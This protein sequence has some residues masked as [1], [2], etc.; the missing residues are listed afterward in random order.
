[1]ATHRGS[2]L[3]FNT[4]EELMAALTWTQLLLAALVITLV[5]VFIGKLFSLL[6]KLLKVGLLVLVV[7]IAYKL[8]ADAHLF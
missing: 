8:I 2:T 3:V 5:V 1:M 7:L 4:A 6:A